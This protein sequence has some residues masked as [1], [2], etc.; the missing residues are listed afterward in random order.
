MTHVYNPL[1]DECNISPLIYRM[2][3][4]IQMSD[5]RAEF[6]LTKVHW[7]YRFSTVLADLL[8]GDSS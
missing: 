7:Q 1:L 4:E 2:L 6:K 3:H 5:V 8:S